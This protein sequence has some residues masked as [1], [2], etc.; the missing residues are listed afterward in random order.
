MS[1]EMTLTLLGKDLSN[2]FS[3]AFMHDHAIPFGHVFHSPLAISAAG[4]IEKE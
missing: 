3:L 1:Q 2:P 4:C